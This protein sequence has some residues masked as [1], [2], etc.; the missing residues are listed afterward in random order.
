MFKMIGRRSLA[1]LGF[2]AV[3]PLIPFLKQPAK[4]TSVLYKMWLKT[5]D[6][7]VWIAQSE[8]IGQP[9]I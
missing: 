8:H 7:P 9:F 1:V 6:K 4:Y 3:L 2:V 5:S